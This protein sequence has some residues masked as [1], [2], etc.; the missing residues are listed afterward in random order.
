MANAPTQKVAV[1]AMRQIH[2]IADTEQ[3]FAEVEK[4]LPPI[5]GR[6]L[7][8]DGLLRAIAGFGWAKKESMALPAR[9]SAH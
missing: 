5:A 3:N 4:G 6:E 8:G 7:M 9:P 1:I 2:S